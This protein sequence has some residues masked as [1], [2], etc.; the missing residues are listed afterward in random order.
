MKE[1]LIGIHSWK[2]YTVLM[3]RD[4][5]ETWDAVIQNLDQGSTVKAV[6]LPSMLDLVQME[7]EGR[8]WVNWMMRDVIL[9]SECLEYTVIEVFCSSCFVLFNVCLVDD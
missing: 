1:S 5:F 9:L 4:H 2:C 7:Q 6:K 8:S 3:Y